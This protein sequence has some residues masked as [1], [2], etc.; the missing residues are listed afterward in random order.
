MRSSSV[1]AARTALSLLLLYTLPA[2][3][4]PAQAPIERQPP[5]SAA[6]P[7]PPIQWQLFESNARNL[8]GSEITVRGT[9]SNARCILDEVTPTALLCHEQFRP[10]PP[11]LPIAWPARSIQFNRQS[12]REVRRPDRTASTLLG[13]GLG[14]ALGA[15]VNASQP[16]SYRGSDI[17]IAGTILGAIGGYIG[18]HLPLIHHTL[19]R[20]R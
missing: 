10:P 11:F 1:R 14:F 5:P 15:G 12:V 20:A 19:Y 6:T 13:I 16:A 17:V 8:P 7:G 18:Y 4:L 9:P 2:T 3:T